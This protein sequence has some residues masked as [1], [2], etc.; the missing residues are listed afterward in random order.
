ALVSAGVKFTR[1]V[2]I[3]RGAH[4]IRFR[5]SFA[6]TDGLTHPVGLQYQVNPHPPSTGAAGFTF[7]GHSTTFAKATPDELVTGLGTKAASMFIRSDI[8]GF[9]GDAGVDTFGLSWSRAPTKIQFAHGS[10]NLFA[11]PY[12]VTVPAGGSAHLG[13]AEVQAPLTPDAKT[14]A[15]VAVSEMM[16]TPT[17][18]SPKSGA[19]IHGTRTTVKGIVA[20]GA[21]GLVKKVSV[22]GHAAHLTISS[23]KTY[24]SYS[25]TFTEAHGTHTVKVTATD[26]A[27]NAR[28]KSIRVKNI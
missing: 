6:S 21:N 11:M 2:N 23:A 3:F 28:S 19:S 10:A 24:V 20:L 9:E 12:S 22:N 8:Y 27:G 1:T 15:K 17:I 18:S 26:S 5:D 4:E 14:R 16:S 13:F 7:P 25:V